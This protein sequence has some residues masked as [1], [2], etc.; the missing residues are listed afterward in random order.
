MIR[1]PTTSALDADPRCQLPGMAGDVEKRSAEESLAADDD[2]KQRKRLKLQR[3][4][5]AVL[6]GQHSGPQLFAHVSGTG[7]LTQQQ[8]SSSLSAISA[9][10]AAT[11]PAGDGVAGVAAPLPPLLL[12]ALPGGPPST[13]QP[14]HKGCQ[15]SLDAPRTGQQQAWSSAQWGSFAAA[16]GAAL[17]DADSTATCAGHGKAGTKRE[18]Q[19]GHLDAGP[20]PQRRHLPGALRG[21]AVGQLWLASCGDGLRPPPCQPHAG[22]EQ[23]GRG[24]EIAFTFVSSFLCPPPPACRGRYRAVA[25]CARCGAAGSAAPAGAGA[26]AAERLPLSRVLAASAASA[27]IASRRLL[28]TGRPCD[29][30]A[31]VPLFTMAAD[32][33]GRLTSTLR[34]FIPSAVLVTATT[35]RL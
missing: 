25:A 8:L 15:R 32:F 22:N 26:S 10:V 31:A 16:V 19:D 3:S 7:G 14:H 1:S 24:L 29:A 18:V 12:G 6:A 35:V 28:Y 2:V 5:P 33:C 23:S 9:A 30:A 21:A 17:T 13:S 11:E 27:S 34:V 20:A 4:E